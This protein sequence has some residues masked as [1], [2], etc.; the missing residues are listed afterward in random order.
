MLISILN[1]SVR[2]RRRAPFD[3]TASS[4]T[5]RGQWR[6]KSSVQERLLK[7]LERSNAAARRAA[8]IKT[9]RELRR[10]S[11]DRNM[12]SMRNEESSSFRRRRRRLRGKQHLLAEDAATT[13]PIDC[14]QHSCREQVRRGTNEANPFQG[15]TPCEETV[16]SNEDKPG[17]DRP[18]YSP[19]S[20]R[21][22]NDLEPLGTTKTFPLP[23]RPS[24]AG[25]NP[26]STPPSM[27]G[28]LATGNESNSTGLQ[29]RRGPGAFP[30][31][32]VADSIGWFWG[33]SRASCSSNN[34][35]AASLE[36]P[37][38]NAIGAFWG[39]TPPV[40]T[41]TQSSATW[42]ANSGTK[43]QEGDYL[44]GAP[45]TS[46]AMQSKQDGSSM[47][48]SVCVASAKA[49]VRSASNRAAELSRLADE[50]YSAPREECLAKVESA[51]RTAR[52]AVSLSNQGLFQ[53]EMM[54]ETCDTG[55]AEHESGPYATTTSSGEASCNS[56]EV[57]RNSSCSVSP[58][59]AQL[60]VQLELSQSLLASS[61]ARKARMTKRF[62]RQ[63]AAATL[64]QSHLR[65]LRARS[66]SRI[67]KESN[68]TANLS[69]QRGDSIL[70][71]APSHE[72]LHP[73]LFRHAAFAVDGSGQ[74]NQRPQETASPREA[75]GWW[76]QAEPESADEIGE[77]ETVL[78]E[79]VVKLQAIARSRAARSRTIDSVN[80]RFVQYFDD[81]YQHPYYTCK[82]T[83]SSQWNRPFGFKDSQCRFSSMGNDDE[84]GQ[85]AKP[86]KAEHDDAAIVIQCAVRAAQA[87]CL[88]T[89]KIILAGL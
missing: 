38:Q 78:I 30:V 35:P 84:G 60:T 70:A 80:A 26:E 22:S 77:N 79:A 49:A 85:K 34:S 17:N 65:K 40:A 54:V 42:V 57:I 5:G 58:F 61:L 24:P 11:H 39:A 4:Q 29:Q 55:S 36:D 63:D 51:I 1:G 46:D 2:V 20:L 67:R 19:I 75:N 86:M 74:E 31:P 10:L 83:G 32:E 16:S 62:A 87:R 37:G 3:H 88:L 69:S 25:M 7:D 50:D 18:S 13:N 45:A 48:K 76:S 6:T 52:S 9:A 59:I 12:S 21:G 71:P 28:G 43:R 41:G 68:K 47:G 44:S 66:R 72:D 15:G 53:L 64:L 33:P 56:K 14:N 73:V 27:I 89:E 82:E 8:A 81:E 23:Q